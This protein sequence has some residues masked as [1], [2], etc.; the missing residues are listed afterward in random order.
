MNLNL[1][2]QCALEICPFDFL[3][4]DLAQVWSS[5]VNTPQKYKETPLWHIATEN[6]TFRTILTG[7][8]VLSALLRNAIVIIYSRG[9]L[10]PSGIRR[11]W[12]EPAVSTSTCP[13][14]WRST[15]QNHLRASQNRKE[16]SVKSSYV[17][18]SES[19]GQTT[20]NT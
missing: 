4:K 20:I 18:T 7:L 1:G 13:W 14:Q 17:L 19:G 9:V 16:D 8:S 6:L 11:E 15:H 5:L 3:G 12:S 2:A 10:Q